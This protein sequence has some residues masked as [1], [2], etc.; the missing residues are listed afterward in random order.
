MNDSQDFA[1]RIGDFELA[2]RLGSPPA[3]SDFLPPG[4]GK[5]GEQRRRCLQ[6]LICIDL[7]YR[8]RRPTERQSPPTVEQYLAQFVEL[9]PPAEAPL[10]LIGEEYR[11]R[12]RWGDRPGHAEFLARFAGREC[13]LRGLLEAIDRELR[14]EFDDSPYAPQARCEPLLVAPAIPAAA[15]DPRAPLP[16][17]DFHLQ[18]LIGSG[19]MGKVYRAWQRSLDRT[20]AV[21]FLRKSFLRQPQAVERF[22]SEART[23]ARCRHAGIVAVHGLGRTA[24]GAYFIVLDLVDGP[25]LARVLQSGPVAEADAVSWAAQACDAIDHAHRLGIVHCDLKPANLL[26][27]SDGRVRVTDFG[28][29]R[30]M[31]TGSSADEAIAGTAPFMA[32]EQVSG[33]W[34]PIG[35]HTDVYGLG[36]LLYT[37]LAGRPPWLG[38]TLADVLSHVVSAAPVTAP[39]VL[40][41]ELSA[42]LNQ[43]CVQCLAKPP[44]ARYPTVRD[45]H[46]ALLDLRFVSMAPGALLQNPAVWRFKTK[47]A[48]MK[49]NAYLPCQAGLSQHV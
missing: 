9:G 12:Q 4:G 39:Q 2:W 41:P 49:R 37:L 30:S 43:V 45:L 6:E 13:Q 21:K 14:E 5:G 1:A 31:G 34:G 46:R 17:S 29:A 38:R 11:A 23:I 18:K 16:A 25:D 32:P 42:R 48:E 44:N 27:G 19:R 26:L 20:V 47:R 40:R 35:P 3:L 22:I 10:E 15:P 8:W 36:A 28:L 33:H 7:E 24:R